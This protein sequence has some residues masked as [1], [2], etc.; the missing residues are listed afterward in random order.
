MQFEI[1]S[2]DG[3]QFY[4]WRKPEDPEKTTDLLQVRAFPE[5]NV[6]GGR[7]ALLFFTHHASKLC[8][9]MMLKY[10]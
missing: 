5:I 6:W 9:M 8:Q 10:N 4:W 2:D 7:K 3:S 1:M